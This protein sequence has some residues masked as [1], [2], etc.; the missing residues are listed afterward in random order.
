MG[1]KLTEQQ[2]RS[3]L[4]ANMDDKFS[5]LERAIRISLFERVVK[6]PMEYIAGLRESATIKSSNNSMALAPMVSYY[7]RPLDTPVRLGRA[8]T[9]F[10]FLPNLIESLG[11][12][13]VG[14]F[15][16]TIDRNLGP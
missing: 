4:S 10:M 1:K 16:R 3:Y 14:E 7:S 6:Q 15:K 11:D 9:R 2:Y 12:V 5:K 8:M 13:T